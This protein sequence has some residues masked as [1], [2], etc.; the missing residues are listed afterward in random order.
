MQQVDVATATFPIALY[1]RILLTSYPL[2]CDSI[3]LLSDKDML[4]DIIGRRFSLV[5][6]PS[7]ISSPQQEETRGKSDAIRKEKLLLKDN[8]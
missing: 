4:S 1:T 3:A 6:I 7:S 2:C 5:C 8:L